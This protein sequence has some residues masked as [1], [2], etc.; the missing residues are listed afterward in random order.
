MLPPQETSAGGEKPIST[1]T[2]NDSSTQ[3]PSLPES[4]DAFEGSSPQ[5]DRHDPPVTPSDGADKEGA[6][7]DAIIGIQGQH[8]SMDLDPSMPATSPK[9][10]PPCSNTSAESLLFTGTLCTEVSGHYPTTCSNPPHL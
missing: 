2:Q 3:I 9:S 7:I 4:L 1:R 10:A 8:P 6:R 5:R